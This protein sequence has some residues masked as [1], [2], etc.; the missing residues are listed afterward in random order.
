MEDELW[1]RLAW[2]RRPLSL[3]AGRYE[4]ILPPSGVADMMGSL[5]FYGMGGQDAEDGRTVFS[6]GATATAAAAGGRGRRRR[7]ERAGQPGPALASAIGSPSVPFTLY[8]DPFEPGLE[9]LPFVAVRLVRL[10]VLRFRQRAALGAH[11]LDPGRACSPTFA[12]TGPVRPARASTRRRT[13]T[14]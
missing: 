6:A 3:E 1:R 11:R 4:V 9:C 14:T 5:F 12:I 2:A 13:S 8:S 7:R 10:G